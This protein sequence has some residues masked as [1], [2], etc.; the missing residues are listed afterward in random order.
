M[1]Q[2]EKRVGQEIDLSMWISY[3]SWVAFEFVTAGAASQ[4]WIGLATILWVTWRKPVFQLRFWTILI[5]SA[6]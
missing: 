5:G 4:L 6:P 1:E 3:F 2:L